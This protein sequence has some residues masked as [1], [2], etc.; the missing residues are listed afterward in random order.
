[1][2]VNL[3]WS[4]TN[5]TTDAGS[6]WKE[7]TTELVMIGRLSGLVSEPFGLT[8][9]GVRLGGPHFSS[10][11][12]C[13]GSAVSCSDSVTARKEPQKEKSHV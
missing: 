12:S 2:T 4:R 5:V 6:K 11:F 10:L 9:E 13:V 3:T 1:M 8:N 7:L